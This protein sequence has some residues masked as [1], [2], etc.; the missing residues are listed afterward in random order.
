MA[1]YVGSRRNRQRR[2]PQ[3]STGG[4]TKPHN[5]SLWGGG[6]FGPY[7]LEPKDFQKNKK[8]PRP[9]FDGLPCV[10]GQ[11]AKW[12]KHRA[13]SGKLLGPPQ[14]ALGLKKCAC[15]GR[16]GFLARLAAFFFF[17]K[18]RQKS[19]RPRLCDRMLLVGAARCKPLVRVEGGGDASGRLP[20]A[21]PFFSEGKT[22][23]TSC[24]P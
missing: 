21:F 23:T 6:P 12:G 4:G 17:P 13:A 18:P 3:L 7:G 8:G 24:S 2:G 22:A 14:P 20:E 16:R 15:G 19:C 5:G 11:E 9:G 10:V 1:I